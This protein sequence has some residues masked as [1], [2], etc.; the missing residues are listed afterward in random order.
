MQTVLYLRERL[1]SQLVNWS[2]DISLP[3]AATSSVQSEGNNRFQ[4]VSRQITNTATHIST[5]HLQTDRHRAV[6]GA[7]SPRSYRIPSRTWTVARRRHAFVIGVRCTV[8]VAV[9]GRQSR[10]RTT[11]QWRIGSTP[12]AAGPTGA[13][14]ACLGAHA[15]LRFREVGG[16]EAVRKRAIE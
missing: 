1:C 16:D 11:P 6:P 8:P 5:C 13:S 3:I 7:T 9:G 12:T 15:V 2:T 10:S 14:S 4:T